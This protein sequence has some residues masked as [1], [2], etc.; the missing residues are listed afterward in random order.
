M[1]ETIVQPESFVQ[2]LSDYVSKEDAVNTQKTIHQDAFIRGLKERLPAETRDTFTAEQLASLKLAFG[3]RPWS[4][5]RSMSGLRS[6]SFV[7]VTTL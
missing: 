1:Q 5:T 7:V 3:T 4:N 6:S 2:G